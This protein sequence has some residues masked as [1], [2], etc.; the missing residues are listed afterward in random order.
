MLNPYI[1]LCPKQDQ[2]CTAKNVGIIKFKLVWSPVH[3]FF[4]YKGWDFRQNLVSLLLTI[5]KK[6][7]LFLKK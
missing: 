5:M 6:T 4:N 1:F 3:P 2:T 7:P